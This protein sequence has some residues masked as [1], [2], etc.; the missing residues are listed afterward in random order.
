[1]ETEMVKVPIVTPQP[2]Q[3]QSGNKKWDHL[4]GCKNWCKFENWTLFFIHNF[5]EF[6]YYSF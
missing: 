3:P 5:T 2:Q 6:N 4:F 1:M